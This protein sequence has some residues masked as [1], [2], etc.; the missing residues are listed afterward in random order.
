[1]L[2]ILKVLLW[3]KNSCLALAEFYDMKIKICLKLI[4]NYYKLT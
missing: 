2:Q 1:M 4:K 3:T